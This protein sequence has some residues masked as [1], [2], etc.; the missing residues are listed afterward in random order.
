MNVR[1]FHND[2]VMADNDPKKES[3]FAAYKRRLVAQFSLPAAVAFTVISGAAAYGYWTLAVKPVRVIAQTRYKSHLAMMRLYDV[4]I[5][6]R[7]TH[8]TYA[9]DLDSLLASVSD[10]PQLKAQ[11]QATT[12][13]ST[14]TVIG[15]A[16]RFR[17]EANVLDPE[18]TL[19][20]FRGPTGG[21]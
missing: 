11:L 9:K 21:R 20:K 10:G 4:Q 12:D 13:L 5:A 6:Y 18:R 14:L 19:V 3:F 16:E 15:D 7:K 2:P 8:D 1:A 17:L